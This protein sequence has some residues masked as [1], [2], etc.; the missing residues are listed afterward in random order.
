MNNRK[1]TETYLCL[2]S[3]LLAGNILFCQDLS[4]ARM[5]KDI[6]VKQDTIKRKVINQTIYKYKPDSVYLK[7]QLRQ[8]EVMDSLIKTKTKR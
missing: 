6:S 5:S 2:F 8:K 3:F 7:E 1:K 4:K